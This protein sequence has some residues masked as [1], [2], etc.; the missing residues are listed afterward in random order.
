MARTVFSRATGAST[1]RVK[2]PMFVS[3]IKRCLAATGAAACLVLGASQGASATALTF[4]PSATNNGEIANG[5][6]LSVG[7][8]AV[9]GGHTTIYQNVVA[10]KT[11]TGTSYGFEGDILVNITDFGTGAGHDIKT[12]LAHGGPG[13][14]LFAV[15]SVTGTGIWAGTPGVSTFTGNAVSDL[16]IQLYGVQDANGAFASFETPNSYSTPVPTSGSL[17]QTDMLAFGVELGNPVPTGAGDACADARIPA[18]CILLATGHATD[19]ALDTNPLDIGNGSSNFFF[20]GAAASNTTASEAFALATMLTPASYALGLDGFFGDVGEFVLNLTVSSGL[21]EGE[22]PLTTT[23]ETNYA[24]TTSTGR[25]ARYR[26]GGSIVG[27]ANWLA[28]ASNPV[29]VPEPGALSL[30]GAGLIGLGVL[31]WHKRKAGAARPRHLR[32]MSELGLISFL[33]RNK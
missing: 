11:P 27:T 24:C 33:V 6:D 5:L 1:Q 13:W 15:I 21:A 14:Q 19:L 18:N 30:F 8:F 17:S 4:N 7:A 9:T 16:G 31:G 2:G 29:P 23:N 22:T 12:D 32:N 10:N 25:C 20:Y 26:A 28:S 3:T